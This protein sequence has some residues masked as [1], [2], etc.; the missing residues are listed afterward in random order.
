MLVPARVLQSFTDGDAYFLA[1]SLR[2][3]LFS[4]AT[5]FFIIDDDNVVAYIYPALGTEGH[6]R[7]ALSIRMN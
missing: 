4:R 2:K 6:A 3:P 5:N 1:H 7:A